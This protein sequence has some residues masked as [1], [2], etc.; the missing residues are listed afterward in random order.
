[1]NNANKKRR[2]SPY[3]KTNKITLSKKK[4]AKKIDLDKIQLPLS[5][6][7]EMLSEDEMITKPKK[8]APIVVT[9]INKNIQKIINDL[10]IKSKIKIVSIGKK[11]FTHSIDD[12]NNIIDA[13]KTNKID[14][15][16]TF[17]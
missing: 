4:K 1:M 16:F 5:N 6:K 14:F 17:R 11:I 10:K 9:D 8:I 15:F 12:K 2:R 7:F 13:L 3:Y